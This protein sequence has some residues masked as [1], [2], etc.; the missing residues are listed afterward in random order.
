MPQPFSRSFWA[1]TLLLPLACKDPEVA[2]TEVRADTYQS[3]LAEGREHLANGKVGPAL[4]AFHAASGL[5]PTRPEPLLLV[6]EANRQEGRYGAAIL[7][8]KQAET[9]EPGTDPVIQKQLADLYRR[10]GH[11][12]QA[13]ST[14]VALRDAGQLTDPEILMLAR[15]QSRERDP[16]GA[17][18]TLERIQRERPDD[19]DAKLTEAEILLLKGEE[20]LAARLM[21]RLVEQAPALTA[22]RLLRARYFLNAGYPEEA[23]KDLAQVPPEDAGKPEV[24]MLQARVLTQQE[25]HAD[26]EAALSKAVDADPR[27]PDLL[28]QLGETKLLLAKYPEA[29]QLVDK[30]LRVRPHFGRALY[31][32]A[33]SLEAQGRIKDA[34]E[35]YRY[36]LTAEPGFAPVLSRMWRL[37]VKAGRKEQAEEALEQLYFMGEASADEKVALAELYAGSKRQLERAR[38]LIDEALRRDPR[39]E[40]YKDI[41]AAIEKATVKPFKPKQ[42]SGPIIIRGGR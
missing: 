30:V 37:H 19:V 2:S 34:E 11:P 17:F 36:A 13:I 15:L 29:Q 39:S 1:L 20:V 16:D 26:A 25:R 22:A 35:S 8:L 4:T 14:L 40:R 24:V 9:L 12:A 10:D 27:N 38:K 42:P 28:A 23:Q 33:R 5:A 6:A 7:A 41:K 3:K 31:V 32:R 21:D 18:Q